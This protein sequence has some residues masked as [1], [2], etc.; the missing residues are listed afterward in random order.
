MAKR[1]KVTMT[2]EA[3]YPRAPERPAQAGYIRTSHY[4]VGKCTADAIEEIK[5]LRMLLGKKGLDTDPAG[6]GQ[7]ADG[8]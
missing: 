3:P 7:V 8:A 4:Y 6:R 1:L 5:M 2:V